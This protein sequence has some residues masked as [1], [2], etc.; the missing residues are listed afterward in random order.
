MKKLGTSELND[1]H[2]NK[3]NF[4][5]TD[6]DSI[7]ELSSFVNVIT[8]AY[9]R[10]RKAPTKVRRSCFP[11]SSSIEERNLVFLV[12]RLSEQVPLFSFWTQW[13][14]A[15]FPPDPGLAP[16]LRAPVPPAAVAAL[17]VMPRSGD[18]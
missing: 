7:N 8:V 3:L 5:E 4:S 16:R 15:Q 6:F 1:R 10:K 18:D 9:R 11:S 13:M 2:G 14:H 12:S 17:V